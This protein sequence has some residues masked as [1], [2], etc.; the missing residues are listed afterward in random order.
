MLL[1]IEKIED[2][3]GFRLIGE[4]DA[5]NVDQLSAALKPAIE[6]GGDIRLDLTELGFMDSSGI[7]AV[8]RAARDLEERGNLI[9]MQP[10]DVV[11]RLLELIPITRL[12]NVE[13][14]QDASG[15]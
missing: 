8:V 9:L 15:S 5:S 1:R 3:L 13:V 11:R 6:T 7:Q 2:P 4:L 12:T 10:G 14:V